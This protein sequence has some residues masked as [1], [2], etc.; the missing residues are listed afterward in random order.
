MSMPFT[1]LF[2]IQKLDKKQSIL[3]GDLIETNLNK[4]G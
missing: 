2:P 4:R 1:S 3:K